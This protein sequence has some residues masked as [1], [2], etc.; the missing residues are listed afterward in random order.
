MSNIDTS[1][2]DTGFPVQGQDNPS[3]GFRDNFSQIVI[4]LDTAKEEIN[5]L[6]DK[7][8]NEILLP[9]RYIS[10]GT[11]AV[12]NDGDTVS[13]D[14]LGF[15]S[16]A[17][18]KLE[19]DNAAWVRLYTDYASRTADL[20]RTQGD[21]PV[22]YS[23]LV[24]DVTTTGSQELIITPCIIGFNNESPATRTIPCS[25]TNLSGTSTNI[26]LTLTLLQQET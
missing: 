4:A 7:F 19:T 11:T 20:G 13:I 3:Q 14:I 22:P 10:S 24:A 6:Q 1:F 8:F 18:L 16:Y 17:L 25:I 15:R 5:S 23:G 2:I 12:T 9:T 26:T 21:D